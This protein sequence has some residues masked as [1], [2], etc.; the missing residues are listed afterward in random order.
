MMA[1]A[2]GL[3]G[4]CDIKGLELRVTKSVH[5]QQ[6]SKMMAHWPVTDDW[7][8][9]MAPT[10]T[11]HNSV[12]HAKFKASTRMIQ[13]FDTIFPLQGIFIPGEG[14]LTFALR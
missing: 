8:A 9:N 5:V 11:S 1:H 3:D 13:D 10:P 6:Q 2:S 7:R 12:V 14:I 4:E